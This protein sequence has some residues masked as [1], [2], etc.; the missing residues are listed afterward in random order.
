VFEFDDDEFYSTFFWGAVEG[1]LCRDE[2]WGEDFAL[3]RWFGDEWPDA[4]VVATWSAY[5]RRWVEWERSNAD[6]RVRA[7]PR[8]TRHRRLR[9][10]I[11]RAL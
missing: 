10:A 7:G 9:L 2:A 1:E 8:T 11:G 6:S 5:E 3:D 4:T